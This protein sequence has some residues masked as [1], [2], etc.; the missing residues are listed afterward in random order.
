MEQDSFCETFFSDSA[1]AGGGG[2]DPKMDI[3]PQV[4][5]THPY[6]LWPLAHIHAGLTSKM[7]EKF[8]YLQTGTVGNVQRNWNVN[9]ASASQRL[10]KFYP[11]HFD[12]I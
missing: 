12:L 9:F 6:Q 2:V 5:N 11:H 8:S 7:G 1:H 4:M 10:T 3:L